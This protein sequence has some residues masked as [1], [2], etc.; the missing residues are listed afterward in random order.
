MYLVDFSL[1]IEVLESENLGSQ[2]LHRA[3]VEGPRELVLLFDDVPCGDEVRAC[4]PCGSLDKGLLVHKLAHFN[5]E[6]Q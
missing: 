2:L 5:Q 4:L 1:E 3:A 6:H